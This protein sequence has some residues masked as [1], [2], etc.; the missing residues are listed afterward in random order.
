V[1]IA[2]L[3]N[4]PIHYSHLLFAAIGLAGAEVEVIFAARSSD[5]RTAAMQPAGTNYRSHYLWDGSFQSLPQIRTALRAVCV[6]ERCR[7]DVV[8]ISGYSYL[9]AWSVLAWAKLRG[10]PVA[11][12]SETNRQYR[13]RYRVKELIKRAFVSACDVGH[14]YGKSSREYLEDLGMMPSAIVEKRATVDSELFSKRRAAFHSDFRRFVFVGRFAPEKNLPRLLEA[15]HIVRNKERAEL[16]M[17][18]YGPL[19]A[20]LRQKTCDLKLND[21]VVFAGPKT[22]EEVSQ[23]LAESDCLVL[24]SLSEPWGLVV[25]EALFTGIPVIVSDR[26][27]CAPDLVTEDTGWVVGAEDTG[28]LAE[29]VVEVCKLPVERLREMGRSA[30]KLAA[31]YCPDASAKRVLQNLEELL[32]R[33]RRVRK[34]LNGHG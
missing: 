33:D 12:W 2:I 23:I 28:K 1:R 10:K 31:E 32:A 4:H 6:L 26:C 3:H 22:Q 16:V 14:V 24:P 27:G 34:V 18:G 7:P 13:Q 21:S 9:P 8:V 5:V 15:F 11:L 20:V 19:E 30:V 17:V 25:N 29:V